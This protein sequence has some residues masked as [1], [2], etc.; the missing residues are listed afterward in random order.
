MDV[1]LTAD[2]F[3]RS[4]REDGEGLNVDVETLG[5]VGDRLALGREDSVDVGLSVEILQV[6]KLAIVVA[7]FLDLRDEGA[8]H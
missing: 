8:A 6:D 3:L 5:V 4:G 7:N 2:I 1:K